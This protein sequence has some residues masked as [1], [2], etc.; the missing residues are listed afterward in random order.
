MCIAD[1][2]RVDIVREGSQA[3][4]EFVRVG[5]VITKVGRTHVHSCTPGHIFAELIE[6]EKASKYSQFTIHF[7]CRKSIG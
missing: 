3:H 4:N 5:H 2:G 7:T 1:G 6:R